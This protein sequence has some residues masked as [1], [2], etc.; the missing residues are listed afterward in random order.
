MGNLKDA[1]E[2]IA[3]LTEGGFV[4]ESKKRKT[5]TVIKD[6]NA[7]D[8]AKL[9]QMNQYIEWSDNFRTSGQL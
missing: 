3:D 8:K 2:H 5:E 6:M 9:R 1:D 7:S 4:S